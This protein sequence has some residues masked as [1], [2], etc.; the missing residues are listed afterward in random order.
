M[1]RRISTLSRRVES[2]RQAPHKGAEAT[3]ARVWLK[4][5]GLKPRIPH[6]ASRTSHPVF[7]LIELLI[8]IVIIAIL[9][10]ML[11]PALHNAKLA[12]QKAV[13]SN[14]LDQVYVGW[15]TYTVDNDTWFPTPGKFL[16]FHPAHTGV[17]AA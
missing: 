15:F 9:A 5:A 14:D 12:A 11:L 7:T 13:C 2:V 10:A 17:V 8:V 16:L 1:T 6:L 4:G 3:A